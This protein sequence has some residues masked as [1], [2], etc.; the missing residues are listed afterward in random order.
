MGL[1]GDTVANPAITLPAYIFLPERAN[2]RG[3]RVNE[4]ASIQTLLKTREAFAEAS[5]TPVFTLADLAVGWI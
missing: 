5:W 4:P 2:S 1:L 3:F